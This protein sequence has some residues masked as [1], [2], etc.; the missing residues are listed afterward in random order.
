MGKWKQYQADRLICCFHPVLLPHRNNLL[1]W[2]VSFCESKQQ[3][4]FSVPFSL[5]LSGWTVRPGIRAGFY[6]RNTDASFPPFH[7]LLPPVASAGLHICMP[8]PLQVRN[9]LRHC[10]PHITETKTNSA[11]R[12]SSQEMEQLSVCVCMFSKN[13]CKAVAA[14]PVQSTDFIEWTC[15]LITF[16]LMLIIK[17]MTISIITS[18]NRNWSSQFLTV[19]HSSSRSKRSLVFL[20][21]WRNI[22]TITDIFPWVPLLYSVC[23]WEQQKMRNWS[24]NR[25]TRIYV[26]SA[27]KIH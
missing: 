24:T 27:S 26:I 21:H 7:I 6:S 12:N 23:R 25:Q 5:T 18:A 10:A 22:L 16:W 3:E 8:Q 20:W 13:Y 11:D 1:C 4:I 2:T 15:S 9:P 17:L 19:N 14:A